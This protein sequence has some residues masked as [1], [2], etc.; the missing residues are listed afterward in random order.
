MSIQIGTRVR[1]FDFS[2]GPGGRDLEGEYA[3]YIEGQVIGFTDIEGCKR[4]K[5]LVDRDVFGGKDSKERVGQ[6]RF[7]PVNGTPTLFS[8]KTDYVEVITS[9]KEK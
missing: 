5:I 3:C 9:G 6:V 1:S 4:Y 8:G 2:R 7:P